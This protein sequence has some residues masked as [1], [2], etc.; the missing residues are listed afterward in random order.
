MAVKIMLIWE[1]I[2]AD[3]VKGLGKVHKG[4][5]WVD[6]LFLTPLLQLPCSK[7]HIYSSTALTGATLALWQQ[8][9]LQ[10]LGQ[11]VQQDPGYDFPCIEKHGDASV[12]I[13]S[14]SV[15]FFL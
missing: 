8:V 11:M 5:H 15:S 13:T 7:Y 3:S 10:L 6:I 1:A 12:V 9:L 2:R 4:D 14:L